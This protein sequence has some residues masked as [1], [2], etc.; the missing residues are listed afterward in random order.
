[1][2]LTRADK[3]Q[4]DTYIQTNQPHLARIVLEDHLKQEP[5]D[6]PARKALGKINARYPLPPALAKATASVKAAAP[7]KATA[8]TPAPIKPPRS[9]MPAALKLDDDEIPTI[10]RALL[11][12]RYDDAEALLIVSDHPDAERLRERLIQMR[13]GI[14]GGEKAKRDEPMPD[15]TGKLTLVIFLLIFLTLFGLIALTIWL[16]EAKRYPDAPGAGGLILANKVT[17]FI[18]RGILAMLFVVLLINVLLYFLR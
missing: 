5:F 15:F 3:E 9:E 12:K 4:I 2:P 16:P 6:E 7:I 13:G 18:L 14:G 11:E 1:M 10:K 8:P 17:T